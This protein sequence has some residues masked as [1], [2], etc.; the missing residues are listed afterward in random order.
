[1]GIYCLLVYIV[2]ERNKMSKFVFPKNVKFK[3]N[4]EIETYFDTECKGLFLLGELLSESIILNYGKKGLQFMDIRC[5]KLLVG[6]RKFY[7]KGIIV[8]NWYSPTGKKKTGLIFD[9][10]IVRLPDDEDY[11]PTSE[12]AVIIDKEGNITKI[13]RAVDYDV[14]GVSAERNRNT[15]RAN[16]DKEPFNII[17]R[18]EW[19]S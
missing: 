15:I 12:H 9:S 3:E 17:N 5:L 16:K 8:N 6:I 18:M 14:C 4:S 19:V 7:D 10:R 2:E 11:S 13:S 1:M